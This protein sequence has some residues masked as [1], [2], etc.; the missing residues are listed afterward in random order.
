MNIKRL[1]YLDP[2]KGACRY[3]IDCAE[4]PAEDYAELRALLDNLDILVGSPSI[5]QESTGTTTVA[6]EC[7]DQTTIARLPNPDHS[8]GVLELV[9]FIRNNHTNNLVMRPANALKS[10]DD[11]PLFGNGPSS[12]GAGRT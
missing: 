3:E 2:G 7:E 5:V 9:E 11:H 10:D 1:I 4:L 12:I 6:V 8:E